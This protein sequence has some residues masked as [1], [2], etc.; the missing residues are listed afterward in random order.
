M[1]ALI[2]NHS[3]DEI[4]NF[5]SSSVPRD[6]ENKRIIDGQ[7]WSQHTPHSQ[8][9]ARIGD[10]AHAGVLKT[11]QCLV[12]LA[13]SSLRP[14]LS[15]RSTCFFSPVPVLRC[16]MQSLILPPAP[17]VTTPQFGLSRFNPDPER[18]IP[19]NRPR[20][21]HARGYSPRALPPP[22]LMSS[23]VPG[24]DPLGISGHARR[25]GHTEL[26]QTL[27]STTTTT[28]TTD[29]PGPLVA[30]KLPA[31]PS[32]HEQSQPSLSLHDESS[33]RWPPPY[34][35]QGISQPPELSY[36]PVNLPPSSSPGIATRSPPQRPTR[37]TKAHVASAC[38]NCK[39]K[40]LGC[41]PARPCRRC[42]LSGKAVSSDCNKQSEL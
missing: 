39:K 34:A 17:F 35:F 37:R 26:P 6:V 30:S 16:Q 5:F 27:S 29:A 38:V 14:V 25:P 1:T 3:T 9:A 31:P 23:S 28:T 15:L 22:R 13:F 32:T 21:T 2:A 4:I 7:G 18:R 33:P 41:D 12:T 8:L 24:D 42:V 40:H 11:Y 10:A 36:P 20:L 19:L